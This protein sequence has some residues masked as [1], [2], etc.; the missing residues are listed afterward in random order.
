[1]LSIR[2]LYILMCC[3][4]APGSVERQLLTDQAFQRTVLGSL[5]LTQ[6]LVGTASRVQEGS[7]P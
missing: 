5:A 1:M 2:L 4:S 7:A 6:P 3:P